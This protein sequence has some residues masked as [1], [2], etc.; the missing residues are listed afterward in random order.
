MNEPGNWPGARTCEERVLSLAATKGIIGSIIFLRP[1]RGL[2]R[3]PS[4]RSLR[5]LPPS[6]PCLGLCRPYLPPSRTRPSKPEATR[7]GRR[8]LPARLIKLT[9]G[10]ATRRPAARHSP[11]AR[12]FTRRP[13]PGHPRTARRPEALSASSSHWVIAVRSSQCQTSAGR[14]KK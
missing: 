9:R 14:A 6:P 12:Q 5:A 8:L 2:H 10:P 7:T 1:P 11:R 13:V 4:P 3:R